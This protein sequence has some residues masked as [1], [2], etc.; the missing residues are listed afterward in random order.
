MKIVCQA[1]GSP[2]RSSCYC[3][4]PPSGE[5]FTLVELLV[6]IA[7]LAILAALLLPA[8]ASARESGR[9]AACSGNL[10]QLGLALA[11][12]TSDAKGILPPP[13]Q[14]SGH[15][16][17]Q[18]RG[19]YATPAILLCPTELVAT[20]SLLTARAK[21]LDAPAR[22]YLFNEFA[23][24]YFGLM[25]TNAT[26][27]LAAGPPSISMRD[28]AFAHP[29]AT[30]TFGEKATSS[31]EFELNVFKP[32]SGYVADLAEGRHSNLRQAPATG[33]ANYAMADGGV[34]YFPWGQDTCPANLWAVLDLWRLDTALCRPR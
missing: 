6:V 18:L 4:R 25:D 32:D 29:E 17:T 22:S 8:L 31:D 21:S 10:R 28:T 13:E 33:G 27:P 24:Y 9:R 34:R 7:T 1:I 23:D 5:A 16:P 14:A 20:P 30:I 19:D 3:A 26:M 11:V 2:R 12:Y 15:W